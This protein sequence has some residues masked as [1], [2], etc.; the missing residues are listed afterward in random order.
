MP[1]LTGGQALVESLKREGVDTIFGLPGVQL[2]WA[3]DALYANRDSINVVHTRHEQ[4][5]AYMADG[6]ARSTGKVGTYIVVPGPGVLNTTAALSTAYST[7]SPVLCITGQIQSDLIGVGRG[8]L[9]EVEGQLEMLKYVTKWNARAMTPNEVPIIVREA[10][11]QLRSGRPQPVEIEIPPDVLQREDEVELRTPMA[12]DKT[13]GDPSLLERAAE[14]LGKAKAPLIIAGGGVLAGE[15][16]EELEAFA[17]LI[18]APVVMTANGRGSLSDRH[19]LGVIQLGLSELLPSS[20]VVLL[21]GSRGLD[22]TT[23]PLKVAAGATL[24]RIDADPY[25]LNRVVTANIAIGGDS[26]LALA[27]LA[28]RVG[29]HNQKR[30]SR[31]EQVAKLK[32]VLTDTLNSAD[33]QAGLGLAIRNSVPDD[34][35]IVTEFTQVGYWA[36]AGLPVYGPRTFIGSGYQGTL[37]NGF[38]TALGAKIGN[39]DKKVVSING[40]G[41]FMFN[42]QELATAVQHNIGVAIIVFDDGAFGNVRRI[43]HESFGGRTIASELKNPSFTELGKTFGMPS[44]QADGADALAGALREAMTEDGPVMIHCPVGVMPNF[45]RQLREALAAGKSPAGAVKS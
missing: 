11:R 14:L 9:H 2:D 38:P 31:R 4:A 23:S 22:F 41:G 44:V 40:D 36:R 24:I 43:Q 3:F 15:A 45:Q 21:V 5:T 33:P 16:W 28:G 34:A 42:A 20:D 18:D 12:P 29:K 1:R 32:Q 37:G 19:P 39:P 30:D 10:F 27:D 25:Q 26:K 8:A 35:I 7:S 6:Y 13:A 17:E